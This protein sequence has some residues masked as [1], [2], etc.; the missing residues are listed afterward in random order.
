MCLSASVEVR[1][2][3]QF[4]CLSVAVGLKSVDLPSKLSSDPTYTRSRSDPS[5]HRNMQSYLSD[6]KSSGSTK[7][8]AVSPNVEPYAHELIY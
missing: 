5:P 6:K 2:N 7:S 3:Q 4:G 1:D 8:V